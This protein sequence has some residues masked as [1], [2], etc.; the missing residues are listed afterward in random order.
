MEFGNGK[1]AEAKP[2]TMPAMNNRKS[3]PENAKASVNL[4]KHDLP[5]AEKLIEAH[6]NDKGNEAHKNVIS[7]W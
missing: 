3:R 5:S 7:K 1:N 6:V 2:V 4:K